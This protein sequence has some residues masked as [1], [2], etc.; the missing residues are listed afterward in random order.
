MPFALTILI[1]ACLLFQVQPLVARAILPWF[2]GSAAVWTAC[3]LFFQVFLVAGYLYAWWLARLTPRRQA[4]IHLTLLAASLLALPILPG[5]AWKPLTPDHPIEHI[6]VL[7]AATTGLPYLLLTTT[8]PLVQSWFARARPGASPY[9]LFALSNLGSLAGLV[10]YPVAVEPWLP[11]RWQ[12]VCWSIAY[13]LYALLAMRLAWLARRL[14][15]TRAADAPVDTSNASVAADRTAS[16]QT[17]VGAQPA[18]DIA[19]RRSSHLATTL[20]WL[21]LPACASVLLLAFTT[22]ITQNIAPMP[23]LWILP[24]GLYLTSFILC[25]A[26]RRWYDRRLYLPLL[27]LGFGAICITLLPAQAHPGID[28]LLPLYAATLFTACMVC[29]GELAR[30]K[31]DPR[32]LTRYYLMIAIGG[33]IGGLLVGIVAPA[34][35]DDLLELP[36][37]MVITAVALAGVLLL[38]PRASAERQA[39]HVASGSPGLPRAISIACL[40]YAC[41]LG[42][43]LWLIRA[44][45]T[46]NSIAAMRNFHGALRVDEQGSGEMRER[47]LT[48]GTITHGKQFLDPARSRWPTTYYAADSG[49]GR[50]ITAQRIRQPTINLG[51]VGLGAG[52]LATYGLAGDRIR[53]YELNPLVRDVANHYFSYLEESPAQITFAMGDARLSMEREPSS[54]FDILAID[55]FSSDSIPV[56][57]LTAEAFAIWFRHIG[58]EGMLAVHISNR[59]LDLEPVIATAAAHL[60]A[61]AR[62]VESDGDNARAVYGS[63]WVLLSK[64]PSVLESAALA[65]ASRPLAPRHAVSL[66]TDDY[67]DLIS[68]LR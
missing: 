30:L 44:D 42:T 1:S 9:R 34:L 32:E 27:A 10:L 16:A 33:A 4:G 28:L 58:P 46:E 19:A 11:L 36:I 54:G 26:H 37:G 29:H 31:P 68:I 39:L 61:T 6:L 7:L 53:I 65:G 40:L 5:E 64:H 21:A 2:G 23:F 8:N 48:H 18:G 45:R 57:L 43:A 25:F 55:A 13:A 62:V 60:G 52:T 67:S 41:G 56:H 47:R 22:H 66:W 49:I 35:F 51:M 38:A 24:L 15:I 63:T 59:Y 17:A 12:S 14:P 3:M 50:A 20:P